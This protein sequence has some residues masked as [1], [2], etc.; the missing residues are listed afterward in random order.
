MLKAYP[1]GDSRELFACSYSSSAPSNFLIFLSLHYSND[2]NSFHRSEK[3]PAT[4]LQNRATDYLFIEEEG[5]QSPEC[6]PDENESP[7]TPLSRP[8]HKLG[9]PL[10]TIYLLSEDLQRLGMKPSDTEY[11][12]VESESE[13]PDATNAVLVHIRSILPG[14]GTEV[15]H[16]KDRKNPLHLIQVLTNTSVAPMCRCMQKLSCSNY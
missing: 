16:S 2:T 10:P 1:L 13:I 9:V 8:M 3:S 6:L 14:C 4:A 15:Y 7:I 11:R 5:V 12:Q